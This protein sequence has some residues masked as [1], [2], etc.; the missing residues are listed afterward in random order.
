MPITFLDR[1]CRHDIFV[2]APLA[3]AP[4]NNLIGSAGKVSGNTRLISILVEIAAGQTT[5]LCIDV[6]IVGG[7]VV[8]ARLPG[9][10]PHPGGTVA[11]TG[12]RA[13][14][15]KRGEVSIAGRGRC[16]RAPVAT[17]AAAQH[18]LNVTDGNDADSHE[19]HASETALSLPSQ[20]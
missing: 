13:A 16:I 7:R 12:Q 19:S 20:A 9:R 2:D 14:G 3:G 10:A 11:L 1:L 15:R 17:S 4:L 18:H 8:R 5:A 6:G